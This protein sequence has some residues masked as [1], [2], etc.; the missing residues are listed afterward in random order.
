M[1]S[2]PRSLRAILASTRSLTGLALRSGAALSLVLG[3]AYCP[4]AAAAGPVAHFAGAQISLDAATFTAPTGIAVDSGGDIFVTDTGAGHVGVW[5]IPSGCSS[6]A[7]YVTVGSGW[8]SPKSVAVDSDGNV[9][10]ADSGAPNLGVWEVA[11]GAFGAAPTQIGGAVFVAPT[12]VA[13][14][15]GKNVFVA[16]SGLGPPLGL[17]KIAFGSYAA[18]AVPI[19][20]LVINPYSVAVDASDNLF[21]SAAGSNELFELVYDSGTHTYA[22]PAQIAAGFTFGAPQGLSLDADGNLYVADSGLNG[23]EEVPAAGGYSSVVTVASVYNAPLGV[24]VQA[25]GKKLFIADTNGKAIDSLQT[26]DIGFGNVNIGSA[27]SPIKLLFTF[28]TGGVIGTPKVVT[29]GAVGRDFIPET[30]SNGTCFTVAN[31]A[32]GSTCT[33]NAT[34]GPM[35]PGL[36]LGAA[37][38]LD[39]SSNVLATAYISGTGVG[40]AINFQPAPENI[41]PFPGSPNL[42]GIAVDATG[43]A[44]VADSQGK[45]VYQIVA[46]AINPNLVFD[47]SALPSSEPLAVAVDGAGNVF[48]ADNPADSVWMVPPGTAAHTFGTP[49]SIPLSGSPSG[50]AVDGGGNLFVVSSSGPQ[51]QELSPVAGGY[52]AAVTIATTTAIGI[53]VGLAVDAVDT[54]FISD[55]T[56][57]QILVVPQSGPESAIGGLN[58]PSGVA[59]DPNGNVYIALP[60]D[61]T[62]L[63]AQQAAPGVWG[64][65]VAISTKTALQNP[66]GVAVD[67]LGNIYIAEAQAKQ[68]LEEQSEL[69]PSFTFPTPTPIGN[70]DFTDGAI[71]ATV[72]NFGNASLNAIAPGLTSP[73]DF[74]QTSGTCLGAFSLAANA[75]CTLGIRF[76]PQSVGAHNGESLTLTDNSLNGSPATQ[77]IT[78][79]GTGAQAKSQTSV[80]VSANP[81]VNQPATITATVAPLTGT[82]PVPLTGTVTFTQNTTTT[83]CAAVP[84]N[85]ATEQ[86]QCTTS[87]LIQG[88]PTITATFS[89]DATNYSGSTGTTTPTVLPANATVSAITS[90]SALATATSPAQGSSNV[91]QS[92]T[93]STAVNLPPGAT[94][95]LTGSVSFTDNGAAI[96]DCPSQPVTITPPAT[97]TPVTCVTAALVGGTHVIQANYSGDANYSPTLNVITQIV[98]PVAS[99]I[100]LA[101]V[102]A[103]PVVG[104]PVT[105]TATVGPLGNTVPLALGTT[106]IVTI[107]N[108]GG[109]IPGCTI[110]YTPATGIATCTTS[111]IPAGAFSIQATYA[112]DPSYS[113]SS[114]NKLTQGVGKS[115]TNTTLFV[116]AFVTGGGAAQPTTTTINAPVTFEAQVAPQTTFAGAPALSGNVA[117]TSD[118]ISIPGC[119]AVPVTLV[120]G[121]PAMALCTTA[122]L[123]LNSHTIVAT[124]SADPNYA[125]S[126]NTTPLTETINQ[127]TDSVT[128][129]LSATSVQINTL[130]TFT[131]TVTPT[132]TIPPGGASPSGLV[133]FNDA[134]T[135]GPVPGCANLGLAV[136]AGA[137]QA[138]CQISTLGT[139]THGITASYASDTNFASNSSSSQS[140]TVGNAQSNISVS[141]SSLPQ[142][143]VPTSTVNDPVQF[144]ATIVVAA[145]PVIPGGTV[146]FTDTPHGSANAVPICTG[147]GLTQ[148]PTTFGGTA[149]FLSTCVYS[150]LTA[151]GSPH[152]ITAAYVPPAT[153]DPF[154]IASGIL[155]NNQAVVPAAS[156]TKVTGAPEPAV[157]SIGNTAPNPANVPAGSPAGSVVLT[158]VVS[159]LSTV[160]LSGSVTFY[161]GGNPI[162]CLAGSVPFNWVTGIQTCVTYSPLPPAAP[163][164]PTEL[165][166]GLNNITATYAD[167]ASNTNYKT[168]TGATVEDVQDFGI[169]LPLSVSAKGVTVTPGHTSANDLFSAAIITVTPSSVDGFSGT[170]TLTC[171]VSPQ[172]TTS[173]LCTPAAQLMGVVGT[174]AQVP[175]QVVIDATNPSTT[176]G[177]YTV[178]LTASDNGTKGTTLVRTTTFQLTVRNLAGPLTVISGATTGNTQTATFITPAGVTL[179]SYTC[180]GSSLAG[181]GISTPVDPSQFGIA[182]T[183]GTPK[184][185]AGSP[186]APQTT[187][188]TVTVTTN[189]NFTPKT[190]ALANHSNIFAAGLLGIPILGLIGLIRGRKALHNSIFRLVAIFAVCFA[191]FQTLG[192]GGSFTQTA[193]VQGGTT[194]PGV[195]YVLVQATGSDG[196]TYQAVIQVDVTL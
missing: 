38:L 6:S 60:G 52:S 20:N 47:G 2:T 147:Q 17:W 30:G 92:V 59:L 43:N 98:N 80:A 181:T 29:Q 24:A 14:D 77:S 118:G 53:P 139:G 21:V 55:A 110:A 107:T 162:A 5:E 57:H 126:S 101:S 142:A 179:S 19:P 78:L 56:N 167:S 25:N 131:A 171:T 180:T 141:S 143:G 102:P 62:V 33:V 36:R 154:T 161:N 54:L 193:T 75:N 128:L 87:A 45:K 132:L 27:S 164:V 115:P 95:K 99:T 46:G 160:P 31:P 189:G 9:F 18:P 195:Y 1:V 48:I 50:V 28:D 51:L 93:F 186:P 194:P 138:V 130:L 125:N 103:T 79:S 70:F 149:T 86:A 122:T 133:T 163:A 13:V 8:A 40:P 120:S 157:S 188:V 144:T 114:S 165:V 64:A 88:T 170:P 148:I 69:P 113:T 174:G 66:A 150:G 16:D 41:V 187:T 11:A 49:V 166:S 97:S 184:G 177:I 192:C 44:Y 191:A 10:V 116:S 158:A 81:T 22:S 109:G 12:G 111:Q 100:S 42:S 34:F 35:A 67:G 89:G 127:A 151:A 134:L 183:F 106:G 140:V 82:A 145:G 91:N 152:K 68:V 168:S 71:I 173:P 90:T 84:V 135:G 119:G 172:S 123:A 159:P 96:A 76:N 108:N 74:Q 83:L 63:K 156:F 182:C 185:T 3:L 4:S 129:A 112:G 178:T 58:S 176:P 136:V 146:T 61:G 39:S 137:F 26:R 121:Q 117:F 175:T 190:A 85:I 153:P 15:A 7:C 196:N 94:T 124:Y 65:P 73:T 23:I 32:T 72:W 169:N 37:E 104:Q 155:L 105:F